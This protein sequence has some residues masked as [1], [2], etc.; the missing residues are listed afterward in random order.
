[1]GWLDL[2]SDL[3]RLCSRNNCDIDFVEIAGSRQRSNK[4]VFVLEVVAIFTAGEA[5]TGF[6]DAFEFTVT[7]DLGIGVIDLERTEEGD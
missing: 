7:H 2:F 3:M 4:F 1:M 5:G 6:V